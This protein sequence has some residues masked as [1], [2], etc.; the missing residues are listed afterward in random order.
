MGGTRSAA[1]TGRLGGLA[2]LAGAPAVLPRA[3]RLPRVRP[4]G[5]DTGGYKAASRGPPGQTSSASASQGGC[6][7]RACS[8][9]GSDPALPWGCPGAWVHGNSLSGRGAGSH[10]GR[11]DTWAIREGAGRYA[12][13]DGRRTPIGFWPALPKPAAVPVPAAPA[14]GAA[15]AGNALSGMAEPAA[16]LARPRGSDG[17]G[18]HGGS[19]ALVVAVE[20]WLADE[21]G[22]AGATS[23]AGGAAPADGTPG[24]PGAAAEPK[25]PDAPAPV[26]GVGADANPDDADPV[27]PEDA[28]PADPDIAD[29]VKREDADPVKA[30]DAD[31]ADPDIADPVKPDDPVKPGEDDAPK[32][33][34]PAKPVEADPP[35]VGEADPGMAGLTGAGINPAG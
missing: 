35:K 23:S 13:V 2:P 5:D 16:S 12:A 3:A 28:D 4:A 30:E 10:G 33:E 8:G 32:P 29:P 15:A 34:D 22:S 31:P 7:G 1:G 14:A 25:L 6:A 20:S 11:P 19:F 26:G 21:A 9:L 24:E 27:K 17:I 18:A